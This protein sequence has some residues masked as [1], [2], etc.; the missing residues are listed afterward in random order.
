MKWTPEKVAELRVLAPH[1]TFAAA[2]HFGVSLN[3]VRFAGVRHRVPLGG[4]GQ[5]YY[6]VRADSEAKLRARWAAM[7]PAKREAIRREMAVIMADG[8]E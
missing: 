8:P 2:K 4:K 1:G 6:A 7:L 5:R 3:S